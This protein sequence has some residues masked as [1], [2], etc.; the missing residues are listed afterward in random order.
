MPVSIDQNFDVNAGIV[1]GSSGRVRAVRYTTD[2]D[3]RR[4]LSS[5][6][7]EVANS[8]SVAM[9]GLP[10][11]C[12]PILPDITDIKFE[13]PASRKRCVIKRKQIPIE[14]GFAITAHKAQGQTMARVIVD[15]A[16]CS[17]TE[18]PYVMLSRCKTLEGLVV[19][20]DFDSGKI[21]KRRSEEL[22]R[23]FN[24]LDLLHWET[25]VEWGTADEVERARREL[26]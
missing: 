4:Y 5:C 16:S 11:H 7:I 18:Q 3:G 10:E 9:K 14:P 15:L 23:E 22:R 12:F 2:G 8:D 1:N 13:H 25:M 26:K 21:T 24:R 6:V 19:L 17:G 20:R